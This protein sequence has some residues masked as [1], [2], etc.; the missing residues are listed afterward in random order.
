MMRRWQVA[1]CFAWI[2]GLA[3]PAF[4]QG[5]PDR[6]ALVIANSDYNM[7]GN[8]DTPPAFSALQGYVTDLR[9]PRHDGENMTQ[10]LRQLGFDVTYVQDANRERMG[11][12]LAMFGAKID[13]APT[14]AVVIIYYAGHAIQVAGRNYLIPVGARIPADQDMSRLP[15]ARAASFIGSYTISTDDIFDQLRIPEAGGLNLVIIDA[16]R[17]NPW[18]DRIYGRN[19]GM[20]TRGM[21]QG[22]PQLSRTLVAYSTASGA[23]AADGGEEPGANSPY[24][25]ALL[26]W[27][28]VPGHNILQMLNN[29]GR[30]VLA[31]TGQIPWVN[32]A[33][34]DEICLAGCQAVVR[35]A[36]IPPPPS[37]SPP[38]AMAPTPAVSPEDAD[39]LRRIRGALAN[40]TYSDTAILSVGPSLAG[41]LSTLDMAAIRR[42]ADAGD[43]SALYLIGAS[44]SFGI[45]AVRDDEAA[46]GW[47]ERSAQAGHP[48]AQYWIATD[49]LSAQGRARDAQGALRWVRAAADQG[50]P[51]AEWL[52]G[53]FYEGDFERPLPI[54]HVQAVNWYR[55]AAGG[56]FSAAQLA[57]GRAYYEGRGIAQD[58][59]QALTWYRRAAQQG[60]FR[61]QTAIGL[62]Y[63]WGHG[64]NAD[65]GQ[66][67]QWFRQAADNYDPEAR[68]MYGQM[69]HDGTAG[70]AL[71]RAGGRSLIHRAAEA[72]WRP[73]QIWL[74]ENPTT[75]N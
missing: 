22:A 21:A 63:Y 61:A 49:M 17:N 15:E 71:D 9:N 3:M 26:R 1:I 74:R 13:A 64:V 54:D 28:S 40:L 34:I 48:A 4:A 31:Q 36:H 41:L 51:P 44:H 12:A 10:E 5:Q 33:P 42:L 52:M 58:Y 67:A 55:R 16:C 8:T 73:A 75:A 59:G 43:A 6:L 24:T 62:I 46:R 66:A 11:V 35:T 60:Q 72:G 53:A 14:N 39:V 18:E 56:G 27:L 7:D 68:F 69:L 50:F 45:E 57:L 23:V 38:V 65:R 29:V 47:Y 20:G 37:A 25:A 30:D 32:N 19:R 70:V 2:L